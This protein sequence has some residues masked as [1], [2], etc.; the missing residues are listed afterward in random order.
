[1]QSGTLC[2]L[3][4]LQ[5]LAPQGTRIQ[6]QNQLLLSSKPEIYQQDSIP[7]ED[8]MNCVVWYIASGTLCVLNDK[9]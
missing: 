6:V 4:E 1:M 5:T 7:R 3:V 2:V 9:H 8:R